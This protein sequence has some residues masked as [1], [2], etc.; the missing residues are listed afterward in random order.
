M[1]QMQTRKTG[2][3]IFF[4]SPSF[5]TPKVRRSFDE[6]EDSV[7]VIARELFHLLLGG[8]KVSGT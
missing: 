1:F 6:C 2:V 5:L 3:G 8:R 7:E 4:F